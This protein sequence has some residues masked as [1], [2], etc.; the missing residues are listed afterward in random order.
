M[1]EKTYVKGVGEV[2]ERDVSGG[3]E[4]LRLVKVTGP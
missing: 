4:T 2:M 1:S 3:D